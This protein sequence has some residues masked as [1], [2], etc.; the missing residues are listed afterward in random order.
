MAKRVK[1]QWAVCSGLLAEVVFWC[2]AWGVGMVAV[3]AHAQMNPYTYDT[4]GWATGTRGGQGGRII[5]VTHLNASGPGSYREAVEAEGPRIVVFEVG[6]VIDM[7]GK[8]ITIKNPYLTIAGQ[9]A[10][11][12]G[13]TVI[14]AETS[15]STHNVIVQ[16]MMFRPGEFGR[17]KRSGHDQDGISTQGNA[18]HV[19]VDHCSLSWA[20]DENLSVGGPR[21]DGA[22]PSDWRRNTSHAITFSYN[23]IYEGLANSVHDKGEHS[24]GS[25]VHDNAN[26]ILLY[27]NIYASNRERN[28]LFKGGVQAAMVNNL[29]FNPGLKAVH[30]NLVAHE[31]SGHEYQ[32]GKV[33]LVGNVYRHGP[34]TKANT[35]LFALGGHGDVEL[36]LQDNIAIDDVGHPVAQTG[37]YTASQARILAV[38]KPYLPGDIKTYPVRDLERALPLAAGARPWARD[39]IDFKLLSD[40]AEGRGQIIDSEV[41]NAMGYPRYLP[42][43]RPFVEADWNLA[44]MSPKAGWASLAVAGRR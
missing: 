31:W 7:G 16:H 42:T 43:S 8:N 26:G 15:I 20:T 21:F 13:I 14:K 18:H 28:A 9:T 35:P 1:Q 11:A 17:A 25:L 3:T 2:A 27:G 30:Y 22:S 40:V 41:D 23:L 38:G 6:G 4:Q 32:T 12:P 34:D 29:I 24:K 10:P 33:T 37:V 5:R 36:Y 19:I 44:D 39:P